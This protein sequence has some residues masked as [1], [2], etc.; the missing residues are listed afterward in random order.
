[1]W[2]PFDQVLSR[3]T[4]FSSSRAMFPICSL[5][6]YLSKRAAWVFCGLYQPPALWNILQIH[7]NISYFLCKRRM[8]FIGSH[9]GHM[10]FLPSRSKELEAW[11]HFNAVLPSWDHQ[12]FILHQGKEY[13]Y[14]QGIQL[15]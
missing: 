7:T 14:L 2:T 3:L 12:L 5:V 9:V 1:M 11:S 10:T 8:I 6:Q 13:R 4:F 15:I